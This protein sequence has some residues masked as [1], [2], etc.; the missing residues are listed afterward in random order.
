MRRRR[1]PGRVGSEPPRLPLTAREF[2]LW[3]P[4]ETHDRNPPLDVD[5][6]C[7]HVV[8]ARGAR[9]TA[10]GDYGYVVALRS[11][12]QRIPG[13]Q[14]YDDPDWNRKGVIDVSDEFPI[15]EFRAQWLIGGW[16]DD[17]PEIVRR[18][19][20]VTVFPMPGHESR[21]EGDE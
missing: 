9:F 18:H 17:W 6:G 21:A 7:L 14:D 3:E 5:W 13:P 15:E 4:D 8:D 19:G 2:S 20:H 1:S 12:E 11:A 16:P 10:L